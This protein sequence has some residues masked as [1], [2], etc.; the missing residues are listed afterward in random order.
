MRKPTK[1]EREYY[2]K[3]IGHTIRGI[4][5]DAMEGQPLPV[6]LLDGTSRDGQLAYAAVLEDPEGNGPGHLDHNL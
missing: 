4:Q 3:L 5:W 1:T 6:L 2:E